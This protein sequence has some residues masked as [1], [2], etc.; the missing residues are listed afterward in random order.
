MT[1]LVN[2]AI[3]HLVADAD[4]QQGKV[5]NIQKVIIA[6]GVLIAVSTGSAILLTNHYEVVQPFDPQWFSRFNRWTG[7]VEFCSSTLF[8][9]T[10]CGAALYLKIEKASAEKS[11]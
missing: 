2:R 6:V 5:L 1:F 8:E 4:Q 7:E 10:Y 11:R 3:L 9:K